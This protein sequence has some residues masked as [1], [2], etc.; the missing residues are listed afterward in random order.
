MLVAVIIATVLIVLVAI[1]L[2]F[3]ITK[4]GHKKDAAK[5]SEESPLGDKYGEEA[6]P[7]EPEPELVSLVD[8]YAEHTDEEDEKKE[9][10]DVAAQKHSEVQEAKFDKLC[11]L[12]IGRGFLVDCQ[13]LLLAAEQD[14]ISY[15][16]AQFDFN[17]FRFI[18][19]LKGFSTG[20]YAITRIANE[21]RVVFP[22]ESLITRLEADQFAVLFPF[23]GDE[24]M[25]E[26]FDQ[27]K[28]AADRIRADIGSKQRIQVCMGVAVAKTKS[29]Y[30]IFTLL[31]KANIAR[32]CNKVTKEESF[33]MFDESMVTTYLYGESAVDDY[34][35]LQ[36][37]DDFQLYLTPQ[38]SV[39]TKRLS[40]C[41]ATASWP[42]EDSSGNALSME[43]GG[44]LHSSNYRVSYHTCKAM[45]RWRKL[46]NITL[47]AMVCLNELDILKEDLDAFYIRVLGE[48][49]LEANQL[50][51][52]VSY[53]TIRINPQVI[54][55]QLT[56]L[57]AV[58]L[59]IAISGFDRAT[60][61]LDS[62]NG[63]K[64][65]IIKLHRSFA[66]KAEYLAER[67][68]DIARIL[69]LAADVGSGTAFEGVDT[70]SCMA[71][72]STLSATFVEGRYVGFPHDVEEFT[73]EIKEMLLT[74]H[75]PNGTIVLDDNTLS[76][77]NFTV[78]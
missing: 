19:T 18:N 4:S 41:A 51:I 74:G 16:L 71:Y 26:T 9:G 73:R 17:R 63:F 29:Q 28:R 43:N 66:H 50:T 11:N 76:R 39:K 59:R 49:Q 58:G 54:I 27:L 40:G 57:R 25:A 23:M 47:P 53:H 67:K 22:P 45:S 42:Y 64:P 24:G 48:F 52:V 78:Y 32:H 3:G 34:K 38:L 62:L 35:E 13:N 21:A 70:S 65:D 61:N 30:D 68:E 14:G 72:F 12:K 15:A 56:K 33:L 8:L 6:E 10:E 60:Q 31:A 46:D 77:G 7:P 2:A 36:Y 5:A 20:D 1:V 37:A 44:V 55:G 69:K 75:D